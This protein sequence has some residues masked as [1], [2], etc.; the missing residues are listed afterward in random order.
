MNICFQSQWLAKTCAA[1][2]SNAV[3]ADAMRWQWPLLKLQWLAVRADAR[4]H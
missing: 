4:A 1:E 3:T 2:D